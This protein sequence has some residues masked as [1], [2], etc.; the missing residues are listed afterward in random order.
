MRIYSRDGTEDKERKS[1][2]GLAGPSNHLPLG[3]SVID[4]SR[5]DADGKFTIL[6]V[7]RCS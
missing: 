6:D 5:T 1:D 3:T 4:D 2:F 7:P